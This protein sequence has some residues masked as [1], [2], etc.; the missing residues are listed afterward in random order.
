MMVKPHV[1]FTKVYLSPTII[2]CLNFFIDRVIYLHDTS[3]ETLKRFTSLGKLHYTDFS[4][5]YIVMHELTEEGLRAFGVDE[6]QRFIEYYKSASL[7]T[8]ISNEIESDKRDEIIAMAEKLA[9]EK[10]L[11]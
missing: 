11:K 10:G 9:K 6:K 4:A 3:A 8:N 7:R 1:S 5:S 2:N